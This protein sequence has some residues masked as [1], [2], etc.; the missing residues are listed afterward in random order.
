MAFAISTQP[1]KYSSPLAFIW[2]P[3]WSSSKGNS[4]AIIFQPTFCQ[5]ELVSS[6][7]PFWRP[8]YRDPVDKRTT[9][10]TTSKCFAASLSSHK[11][12]WIVWMKPILRGFPQWKIHENVWEYLHILTVASTCCYSEVGFKVSLTSWRH[13]SLQICNPVLTLMLGQDVLSADTGLVGLHGTFPGHLHPWSLGRSICF[14]KRIRM[15]PEN[16]LCTL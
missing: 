13:W 5:G 7:V 11:L 4:L 6:G 14:K 9:K 16:S 8:M 15:W 1:H 10:W 12:K 3:N 2:R